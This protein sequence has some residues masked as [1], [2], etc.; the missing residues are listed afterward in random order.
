MAGAKGRSGGHNRKPVSQHLVSGT[1]RRDRH[2]PLPALPGH[3]HSLPVE[4][5]RWQPTDT[6]LEPMPPSGRRFVRGWL[7]HYDVTLAE[8]AILLEA[9]HA[10][11]RLHEIRATI[12]SCWIK[13]PPIQSP[14]RSSVKMKCCCRMTPRSLR[15][16]PPGCCLVSRVVRVR[17]QAEHISEL[18]RRLRRLDA[19]LGCHKKDQDGAVAQED[20][21]AEQSPAG[22]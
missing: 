21:N 9:G 16:N 20:R 10:T 3:V 15:S 14:R 11:G 17:E 5:P 2:G 6:D 22:H 12:R 7:K 4:P 19:C 8:G 18:E 13:S 1:Y